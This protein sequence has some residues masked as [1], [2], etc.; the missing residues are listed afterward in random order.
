MNVV[1]TGVRGIQAT[2]P[3]TQ[4]AIS[5]IA[6][7]TSGGTTGG[8]G[9]APTRGKRDV[10]TRQRDYG[11]HRGDRGNPP[12][13]R[14]LRLASLARAAST[15]GTGVVGTAAAKSGAVYGV[16]GYAASTGRFSARVQPEARTEYMA[17]APAAL[18][19]ESLE[20]LSP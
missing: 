2:V 8:M 12:R 4:A 5:G 9:K 3:G 6:T 11:R 15:G 14:A 18:E 20:T 7:A 1:G 10:W 17:R 19:I 13:P 16:G